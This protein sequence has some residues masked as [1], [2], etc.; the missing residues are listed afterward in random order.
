MKRNL[1][2]AWEKVCNCSKS[3][4]GFSMVEL[5]IALMIFGFFATALFTFMISTAQ[6][7]TKVNSSTNLSVQSQVALGLIEEYLVDCSG[8][9]EY[10]A[11]TQTLYIVNNEGYDDPSK[12]AVYIY[13]YH[14][15]KKSLYYNFV[16]ADRVLDDSGDLLEWVFTANSIDHG[17]WELVSKNIDEF[18][19]AF[20]EEEVKITSTESIMR[21]TTVDITLKMSL[22]SGAETYN[23]QSIML[24]RNLPTVNTLNSK[25]VLTDLSV[26]P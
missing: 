26:I 25:P 23:G 9:V 22:D 2:R 10:D 17:D 6:V 7:S 8:M 3:N 24:L 20:T 12:A 19:V 1:S 11:T 15:S 4:E 14:P 21:V 18:F 16:T 5:L 13:Q